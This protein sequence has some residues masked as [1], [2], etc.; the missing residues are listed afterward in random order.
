MGS[1]ALSQPWKVF[2]AIDTARCGFAFAAGYFPAP[3]LG[4][5]PGE[6]AGLRVGAVARKS[7]RKK[8]LENPAKETSRALQQLCGIL[9]LWKLLS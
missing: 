3:P 5:L 9:I 6:Q 7:P 4:M 8:P 2:T 1:E